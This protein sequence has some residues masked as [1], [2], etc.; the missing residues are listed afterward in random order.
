MEHLSGKNLGV[1]LVA[2][3][4]VAVSVWMLFLRPRLPIPAGLR[5]GFVR[6]VLEVLDD[7]LRTHGPTLGAMTLPIGSV[8]VLAV[9]QGGLAFYHTIIML[10]MF[11]V[12]A[13]WRMR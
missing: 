3:A 11:A 2:L 5:G 13:V 12:L 6:G 7:W 1:F 8:L 10:L 4:M 9:L